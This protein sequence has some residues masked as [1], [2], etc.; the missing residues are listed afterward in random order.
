MTAFDRV[1]APIEGRV[2]DCGDYY[3]ALEGSHRLPAA[4]ARGLTPGLTIR[5]QDYILEISRYDWFDAYNWASTEYL[6]GE[7]AVELFA[8]SQPVLYSFETRSVT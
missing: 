6:A 3:M 7:V 1:P 8:P 2:I 4:K 5:H